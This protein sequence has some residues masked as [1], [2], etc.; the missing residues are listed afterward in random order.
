[1]SY[2]ELYTGTRRVIR[3]ALRLMDERIATEYNIRILEAKKDNLI[4]EH[5]C[6]LAEMTGGD[7]SKYDIIVGD[8]MKPGKDSD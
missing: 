5:S 7:R 6:T 1:M 8:S 4:N 2:L 3:K